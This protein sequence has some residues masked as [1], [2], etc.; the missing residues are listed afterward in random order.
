MAWGVHEF[1]PV[2]RYVSPQSN[3]NKPIE[4][5]RKGEVSKRPGYRIAAIGAHG[6]GYANHETLEKT[7]VDEANKVCADFVII[8]GGE[9]T[10]DEMVGS[11][12]SGIMMSDHIRRPHMYAVAFRY[13]KV[14][15]G[16]N[17][18]KDGIIEY[19]R[20]GSTADKVGIK[21]GYKLLTVNGVFIKGDPFVVD[22]EI[23]SKNP[24]DKVQIEYMDKE[25]NK[26]NKNILLE[27]IVN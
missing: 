19:V 26:I 13:A 4:I 9:I 6:N 18:D 14:I 11:Y 8:T 25:G 7:I 3:C 22:R 10:K 16:V 1:T 17:F 20:T 23:L 2:A 12:G 24:G 5:F 15:I 21:E 27:G